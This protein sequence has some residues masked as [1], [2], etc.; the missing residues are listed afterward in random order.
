MV[1]W[2]FEMVPEGGGSFGAGESGLG[3]GLQDI[4]AACI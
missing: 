3:R 1:R 4:V 2:A